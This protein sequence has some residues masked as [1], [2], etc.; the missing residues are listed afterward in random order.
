MASDTLVGRSGAPARV[1]AWRR[2]R[3]PAW[4][5]PS[6]SLLG[7]VELVPV[8]PAFTEEQHS[9]LSVPLVAR[10]AGARASLLSTEGAA[11]GRGGPGQARLLSCMERGAQ[12]EAELGARRSGGPCLGPRLGAHILAAHTGRQRGCSRGCSRADSHKL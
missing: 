12:E 8:V 3:S 6:L 1:I 4:A 5:M 7:R 11:R 9:S 2:K 10:E